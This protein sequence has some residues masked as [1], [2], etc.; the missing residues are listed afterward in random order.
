MSKLLKEDDEYLYLYRYVH[1]ERDEFSPWELDEKGET[2][3]SQAIQEAEHY[4]AYELRVE[5]RIRKDTGEVF[6]DSVG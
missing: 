4:A 5:Y 3:Y 1:D 2:K 6:Y